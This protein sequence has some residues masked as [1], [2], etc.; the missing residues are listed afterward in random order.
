MRRISALQW[1]LIIVGALVLVNLFF[2]VRLAFAWSQSS[3]EQQNRIAQQRTALK[4]AQLQTAPLRGLDVLVARSSK[5]SETFY[6]KRIPATY[7]AI[8]GEL[9]KVAEAEHVKLTRVQYTQA[10][11]IEGLVEVRV[12]A[13]LSGDYA[14]LVKMISEIERDKVFFLIDGL[15]LTGQQS[16]SVNLRMR[17]TTYLRPGAAGDI[18]AE[19]K[20]EAEAL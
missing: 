17:L 14:P 19:S 18:P 11:P 16:G 4:T 2:L 20:P 6:E 5:D 12:D 10:P 1:H 7:S 15:T 9:G 3:A 13:S 8:A